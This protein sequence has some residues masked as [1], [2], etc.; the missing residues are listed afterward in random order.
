MSKSCLSLVTNLG[1]LCFGNNVELPLIGEFACLM[2]VGITFDMC[3]KY[4]F[5]VMK[6]KVD[7][8]TRVV[9]DKVIGWIE[10]DQFLIRNNDSPTYPSWPLEFSAYTIV[11]YN[12]TK[13]EETFSSSFK[14]QA[15]VSNSSRNGNIYYYEKCHY[16][17]Q[18]AQYIYNDQDQNCDKI[19]GTFCSVSENSFLQYMNRYFGNIT[20]DFIG[21]QNRDGKYYNIWE[22]TLFNSLSLFYVE[23]T[24]TRFPVLFSV[25]LKDLTIFSSQFLWFKDEVDEEYFNLPD[26]CLKR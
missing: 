6:D 24:E 14:L 11:I 8:A 20:L 22:G 16:Q 23:E 5:E 21:K 17:D 10:S 4:G 9:C 12:N 2:F 19:V 13:Y 18:Q 3:T 7:D 15:Y 26:T 25:L 1:Y